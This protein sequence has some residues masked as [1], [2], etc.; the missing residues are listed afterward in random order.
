MVVDEDFVMGYV[1]GQNNVNIIEKTIT[2]SGTYHAADDGADGFDPVIVNA[3]GL[4]QKDLDDLI[5]WLIDQIMPQLPDGTPVPTIPDIDVS[6]NLRPVIEDC[7][8]PFLTNVSA[9]GETT[10]IMYGIVKQTEYG[11]SKFFYVD[12]YVSGR[13]VS[14]G[15]ELEVSGYGQ[16]PGATAQLNSDGSVTVTERWDDG[17]SRTTVYGPYIGGAGSTTVWSI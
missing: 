8:K 11:Q 2:Q 15:W 6:N 4:S 7:D 16:V 5:D 10:Q 3:N 17:T 9:D 13:L 1:V 14:H 12:T